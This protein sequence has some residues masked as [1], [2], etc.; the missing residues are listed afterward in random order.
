MD[1]KKSGGL[2]AFAILIIL[3][4]LSSIT[5]NLG[6]MQ[7]LGSGHRGADTILM[8]VWVAFLI[9]FSLAEIALAV[10]ILKLNDLARKT[11]IIAAIVAIGLSL[12]GYRNAIVTIDKYPDVLNATWAEQIKQVY[13]E[14]GNEINQAPPEKQENL[15]KAHKNFKPEPFIK[16]MLT[17]GVG[18]VIFWNALL[19][20]YFTRPKVKEQ[21]SS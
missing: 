17:I 16:L 11:L 4:S 20:F 6:M 13:Q 8:Q 9:I 15:R 3:F 7:R 14:T 12:W 10:Y 1:K 19:I 5:S 21:F 18:F 2:I